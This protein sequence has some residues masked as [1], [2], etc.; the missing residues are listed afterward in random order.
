M[1]KDYKV[2]DMPS[3]MA[4]TVTKQDPHDSQSWLRDD[5]WYEQIRAIYS[6]LLSFFERNGLL[7]KSIPRTSIDEVVVMFSD[8]N[9]D[10]QA[11]VRS[12]AD[13]KWLASFDRPG[14]AKSPSNTKSLEK[15]LSKIKAV[16]PPMG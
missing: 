6:S 10:G 5:S 15:A 14:A 9:D 16:A 13:D 3:M 12:G 2:I 7:K 11:L 8:L 1:G 4:R